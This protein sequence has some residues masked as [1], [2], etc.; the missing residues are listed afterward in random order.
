MNYYIYFYRNKIIV[1]EGKIVAKAQ[2]KN[3]SGCSQPNLLLVEVLHARSKRRIF[4]PPLHLLQYQ[5]DLY[6][7][8]F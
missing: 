5:E 3:L 8:K 6:L 4:V 2:T 1:D 7:L